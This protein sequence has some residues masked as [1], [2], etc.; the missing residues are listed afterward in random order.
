[1]DQTIINWLLITVSGSLGWLMKAIWDAIKELKDDLK[2]MQREMP[3]V[4]VRRDDFRAVVNDIKVEI[5]DMKQ[6]LKG[7]FTHVND[8][9]AL[10]FDKL[11]EKEDRS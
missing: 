8:T 11:N 10:I 5:R 1:M 7:S 9:L 3:A 4:Y 2:V 6:D